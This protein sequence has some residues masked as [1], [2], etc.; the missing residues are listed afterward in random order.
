MYVYKTKPTITNVALPTTVLSGGTQTIYKFTVSADAGGTVVWRKIALNI[1]T[2]GSAF[3]VTGWTLY[4]S[5]NESTA[6]ANVSSVNTGSIVTFTSTADQEVSGSKAYVVKAVVTG[7]ATG[8]I[9][10]NITSSGFG[11]TAPANAATV[12]STDAT[13]VWSDE[14][15]T[16]HSDT[17]ADWNNDYLVKNLPTES[18]TLTR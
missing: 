3:T 12:Q 14:S 10:T 9:S 6:L 4:D 1:A 15:I 5:A 2:S 16:T 8:A 18:L 7:V 11:F 17:T 13:F